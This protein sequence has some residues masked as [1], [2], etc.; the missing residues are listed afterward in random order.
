MNVKDLPQ[1][2]DEPIKQTDTRWFKDTLP[3]YDISGRTLFLADF[4]FAHPFL[5]PLKLHLRVSYLTI[6]DYYQ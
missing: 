2:T 5:V 3:I 1:T 4:Y 6:I